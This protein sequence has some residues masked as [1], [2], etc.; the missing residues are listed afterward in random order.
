MSC[1]VYE[2]GCACTHDKPKVWCPVILLTN[3]SPRVQAARL[4]VRLCDDCVDTFHRID[5][6]TATLDILFAEERQL[7]WEWAVKQWPSGWPQP[8]RA[9]CGLYFDLVDLDEDPFAEAH[10]WLN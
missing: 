2:T 7:L 9:R 5:G 1:K 4:P 10:R 6:T 3:G 8:E